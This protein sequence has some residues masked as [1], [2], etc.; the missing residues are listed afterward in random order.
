MSKEKIFRCP[1]HGY[2]TI[3]NDLCE[4]FVDTPIFQRLKYIEQTNMRPLYPSAHHNRFVHS[5]GVYHLARNTYSYLENN[6]RSLSECDFSDY[7]D[8]YRQAFLIAALMHD[9]AHAPF[10]HTLENYL[11]TDW[12][13][14]YL[15][16]FNDSDVGFNSDFKSMLGH[17]DTI[18]KEHELF[19]AAILLKAFRIKLGEFLD[20]IPP[21]LL[22]RMITGCKYSCSDK[23]HQFLNC[24]I[25]LINGKTIDVDKL[26]Y[27]MRD[28]LVSGVQSVNIDV[29]RLL[30]AIIIVNRGPILQLAYNKAALS[31]IQS[32]VDGKN[33][34]HYWVH[35]HHTVRYYSDLL[36]KCLKC[37]MKSAGLTD[38]DT[39]SLF[40]EV[41]FRESVEIAGRHF[42]LPTDGDLLNLI[43]SQTCKCDDVHE[44][45]SRYPSRVPV[46]KTRAEFEMIFPH[47]NDP[48][49]KDEKN[50]DITALKR[51]HMKKEAKN[52]LQNFRKGWKWDNTQIV[53]ATHE[54]QVILP[55][56]IQIIIQKEIVPFTK[57]VP[58]ARREPL[59]K[60][61]FFYIF[62]PRK[63]GKHKDLVLEYL[64]KYYRNYDPG[65]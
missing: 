64:K 22:A 2:V 20:T 53:E 28:V 25:E 16:R 34:L 48:S 57:A 38:K 46:W 59:S 41:P 1:V 5:V 61:K 17:P 58:E 24:L 23:E 49:L 29:N 30:S 10:S 12:A 40:S 47:N 14:G 56:D 19:S 7:F 63:Y 42:F 21:R 4:A 52:I 50:A 3:P 35:N 60:E 65:I 62:I 11:D 27:I 54:L 44:L 55:D 8:K 13:E 51:T 45:L 32:V 43:K 26:D 6:S 31:V 9:C 18:P 33:F 37:S 15:S 39:T 36:D